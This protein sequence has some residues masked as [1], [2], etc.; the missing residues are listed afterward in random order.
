MHRTITTFNNLYALTQFHG[1]T[2]TW[3]FLQF[4]VNTED[5]FAHKPRCKL[6][7]SDIKQ[8]NTKP[9]SASLSH[10]IGVLKSNSF[11]FTLML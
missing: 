4:N 5:V 7:N 10:S 8:K 1:N 2:F 11:D 9:H 3:E 6:D